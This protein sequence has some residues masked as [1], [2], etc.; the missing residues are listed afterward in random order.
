MGAILR[1]AFDKA[2][3]LPLLFKAALAGGGSEQSDRRQGQ[4]WE[5]N[6]RDSRRWS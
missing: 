3:R 6:Q 4:R 5:K 2:V 1:G